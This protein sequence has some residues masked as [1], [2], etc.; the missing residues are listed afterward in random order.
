MDSVG[1]YPSPLGML[2]ITYEGSVLFTLDFCQEQGTG[3]I[4][5]DAKRWLDRYFAGLDPGKIPAFRFPEVSAFRR[6]VWELLLEIPYGQTVT[7]GELAEKMA[8]RGFGK[9]P[10]AVGGA[11]GS[12]PI[13]LMVPCHRVIGVG[14]RL[15]GYAWGLERKKALLDLE[16][17]HPL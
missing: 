1:Y 14:G 8:A 15:T 13:S 12:N 2:R 7:Y 9:C 5:E 4:P 11:V 10:Q 6:N 16:Q 3:P 17:G